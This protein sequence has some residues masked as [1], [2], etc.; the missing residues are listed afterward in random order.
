MLKLDASEEE[1][2]KNTIK[3]HSI[4][5]AVIILNLETKKLISNQIK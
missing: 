2:R 3:M 1:N 4:V 5:I